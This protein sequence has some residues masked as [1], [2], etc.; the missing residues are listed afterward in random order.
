LQKQISD[1]ADLTP[2]LS[3][4]TGVYTLAAQ[5]HTPPTSESL[6]SRSVREVIGLPEACQ[7]AETISNCF[8]ICT[9]HFY[10]ARVL[11]RRWTLMHTITRQRKKKKKNRHR[12]QSPAHIQLSAAAAE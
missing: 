2:A 12:A 7:R 11:T 9:V 3:A 8:A 10:V 5:Q 6:R 1:E 4:V